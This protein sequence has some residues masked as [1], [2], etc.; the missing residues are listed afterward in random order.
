MPARK[1]LD[2]EL[3]KK[4]YVFDNLKLREIGEVLGADRRVVANRIK[5]YGYIQMKKL[6]IWTASIRKSMNGR[7]YE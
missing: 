2:V 5:E 3:L 6:F 7:I 1:N 4:L